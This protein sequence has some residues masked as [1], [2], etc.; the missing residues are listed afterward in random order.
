MV[1]SV[2]ATM[3]SV[4]SPCHCTDS[5]SPTAPASAGSAICQRRSPR[6]SALYATRIMPITAQP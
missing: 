2:S 3:A 4:V 6:L 1:A 5:T